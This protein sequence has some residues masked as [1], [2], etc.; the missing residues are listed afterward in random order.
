MNPSPVRAAPPDTPIP[1]P[2]ANLGSTESGNV[3]AT[4]FAGLLEKLF[5]ATKADSDREGPSRPEAR[6]DSSRDVA[7]PERN[8]TVKESSPDKEYSPSREFSE[9][10][11]KLHQELTHEPETVSHDSFEQDRTSSTSDVQPDSSHSNESTKSDPKAASDSE[12]DAISDSGQQETDDETASTELT[13]VAEVVPIAPP[14]A[15]VEMTATPSVDLFKTGGTPSIS[16]VSTASM[17]TSGGMENSLSGNGTPT[18]SGNTTPINAVPNQPVTSDPKTPVILAPATGLTSTAEAV[19]LP[20]DVSIETNGAVTAE[21]DTRGSKPIFGEFLS[22]ST[23]LPTDEE[24]LLQPTGLRP[25]PVIQPTTAETNSQ[26]SLVSS[27]LRGTEAIRSGLDS[28]GARGGGMDQPGTGVQEGQR[29]D[30]VRHANSNEAPQRVANQQEIFD[31]IVKMA[32]FARAGDRQ[33]ARLWL[34][35]PALGSVRIHLTVEKGVVEAQV[36][37][38]TPAARTSLSSGLAELR[39]A[40]EKHGLEIGGFQVSVGGE[41]GEN[42]TGENREANSLNE[43]QNETDAPITTGDEVP[44]GPS[45]RSGLG[46]IDLTI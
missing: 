2:L 1:T 24:T 3:A 19:T 25:I 37:T 45:L 27:T 7:K 32:R 14:T 35:P 8:N 26:N 39:E 41:Q 6:V 17:T 42:S 9:A 4:P 23:P 31:R 30:S 15:S 11:T 36:L 20:S 43:T 46:L 21:T 40:L 5:V 34:Q 33:S 10:P 18:P 28:M 13:D 12:S 29:L 22:V 38:E 16:S 44:D